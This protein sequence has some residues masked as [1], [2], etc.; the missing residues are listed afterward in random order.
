MSKYYIEFNGINSNDIGFKLQRLPIVNIPSKKYE[1]LNNDNIDGKLYREKNTYNTF[2]LD[3]DCIFYK[4][5]TQENRNLLTNFIKSGL[6]DLVLGWEED[7]V[8]KAKLIN[9]I[10]IM[11]ITD[12]IREFTLKFEVQPFKIVKSGLDQIQVFSGMEHILENKGNI[13]TYPIVKIYSKPSS[14]FFINDKEY[15]V[16]NNFPEGWI[17]IDSKRRDVYGE[18]GENLNKY[19]NYKNDFPILEE[20]QNKIYF[21]GG[22]IVYFYIQP[23]WRAL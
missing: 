8:Y 20:G 15:I 22:N 11:D 10:E 7:L 13:F 14:S 17:I 1:E 21:T 12:S 2:N 9:G 23:N 3:I 16:G 5:Y 18:N 6:G 4:N 19:F